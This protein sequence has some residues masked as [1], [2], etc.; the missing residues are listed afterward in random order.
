MIE[1]YNNSST[2]IAKKERKTL[3][4]STT[5]SIGLKEN[6]K[7][8]VNNEKLVYEFQSATTA[9]VKIVIPMN[10]FNMKLYKSK[11]KKDWIEIND[12][13]EF[14]IVDLSNK[15]NRWEGY[16]MNH[17]PCGYGMKYDDN[18]NLVYRGFVF[19]GKKVCFGEEYYDNGIIEYRGNYINDN[20]HGY[21]CLYDKKGE[22]IYKGDWQFN[23]NEGFNVRI[24]NGCDDDGLIHN[25]VRELKIG[26]K[27]YNGLI[28]L[29]INNY[30][31]LTVF[32]VGKKSFLRII[33]FELTNCEKLEELIINE[34]S[35]NNTNSC[36]LRSM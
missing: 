5:Y 29:K 11:N 9:F 25:L 4:T 35:M 33:L 24:P 21:G 36:Q 19:N 13:L 27:C 14:K 20:R 34:L 2:D 1:E 17:N 7:L 28:E 16:C 3:N 8:I 26:D 6:Y 23:M 30:P 15:G 12:E 18:K 31:N 22:L 10:N 32:I